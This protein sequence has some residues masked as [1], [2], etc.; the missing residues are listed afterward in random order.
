MHKVGIW[1]VSNGSLHRA[2]ESHIDFERHLE[3]WI[4]ADPSLVRGGLTIVGRQLRTASGPLDL[5]ALEPQG[6]WVI[7]EVKKGVLLRETIAQAIDY[8]AC[9]AELS[10]SELRAHADRYLQSR[11]SLL[12]EILD[13]WDLADALARDRRQIGLIV[14]GVGREAGLERMARF[15]VDRFEMPLA[16]VSFDVFETEPG[17]QIL[18]RE[19]TELDQPA[20]TPQR[21]PSHTVQSVIKLAESNGLGS[22][23]REFVT[24]GEELGFYLRVWPT[25]IMFAPQENKT[26]MLYTVWAQP[27][28]GRLRLYVSPAAMSEFYPL[29]RDDV[30]AVLGV[31]GWRHLDEGEAREFLQQIRTVFSAVAPRP[32][33]FDG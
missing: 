17:C 22:I 13:E 33:E 1:R 26:R 4:E 23:F 19:I 32:I 15:L 8:A 7:I 31:D 2:R 16:I 11:N 27:S 10:D 29:K 12:A 14:V 25:S 21:E 18:A 5:L 3:D 24:T 9:I 20:V 30:E 6:R 28:K